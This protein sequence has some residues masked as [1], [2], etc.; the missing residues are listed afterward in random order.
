[1]DGVALKQ[2]VNAWATAPETEKAARFAGAESVRWLEWGTRSYANFT[3]ALAILS[4]AVVVRRAPLPRPIAYVMG[5]AALTYVLQGWLAGA[6]VFSPAHTLAI[7]AAEALNAVW[8][9]WLL[10]VAF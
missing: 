2:A 1:V 9:A 3:L 8:M 6:A 4:A 7:V 5:L 10:M